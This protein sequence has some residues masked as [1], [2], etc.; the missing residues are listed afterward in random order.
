MVKVFKEYEL[1]RIAGKY[2]VNQKVLKRA[3]VVIPQEIAERNNESRLI[4]G[5]VWYEV[6][7][8][9]TVDY[10]AKCAEVNEI[11]AAAKLQKKEDSVA[12]IKEVFTEAATENIKRRG[13]KKGGSD[14]N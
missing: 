13:R 7:E 10:H 8:Q 5:G 2:D 11:R 1:I 14:E 9:A 6:D 4:N 3:R 12:L